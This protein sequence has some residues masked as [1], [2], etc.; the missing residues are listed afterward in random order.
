MGA[1]D[2]AEPGNSGGAAYSS[3]WEG[4]ALQSGLPLSGVQRGSRKVRGVSEENP[5]ALQVRQGQ[6]RREEQ[7]KA[8]EAWP[9]RGSPLLSQKTGQTCTAVAAG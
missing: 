4:R 5:Q 1:L 9:F 7:K 2:S 8:G 6:R 3:P